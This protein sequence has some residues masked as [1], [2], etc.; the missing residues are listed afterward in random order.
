MMIKN[1]TGR[2]ISIRTSE[3]SWVT[4]D[5]LPVV[6]AIREATESYNNSLT[7]NDETSVIKLKVTQYRID[8]PDYDENVILLVPF[9]VALVSTRS[10]LFVPVYEDDDAASNH[11][12]THITQIMTDPNL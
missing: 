5:S 12:A 6:A 8:L 7:M 2:A 10:D 4:F 11:I 3:S 1:Y 9:Q